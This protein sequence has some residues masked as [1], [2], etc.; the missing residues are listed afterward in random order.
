MWWSL[1]QKHYQN[2]TRTSYLNIGRIDPILEGRERIAFTPHNRGHN[3][4]DWITYSNI[5]C[6]CN[7]AELYYPTELII[8]EKRYLSVSFNLNW[9]HSWVIYYQFLMAIQS[10]IHL[11]ISDA[12]A[13]EWIDSLHSDEMLGTMPGLCLYQL[14][15]LLNNGYFD[16]KNL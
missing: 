1:F 5:W 16:F 2:A 4:H 13:F 10:H 6:W 14:F 15:F 7:T 11:M 9:R 3:N 8:Y 12:L